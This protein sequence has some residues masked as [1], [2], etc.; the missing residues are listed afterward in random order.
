MARVAIVTGGA[1]E[2][3]AAAAFRLAEEGM[4]IALL[5]PDET[6]CADTVRRITGLGHRCVVLNTDVT[7][8]A[9][10]DAA[11]TEICAVLGDP[12]V[13]LNVTGDA[14]PGPLSGL[15]EHD[16]Y[17]ST[18]ARLRGVFLTSRAVVDP[19]IKNGWGRIL[20]LASPGHENATLR[21][22]LD[23]VLL[24]MVSC[25]TGTLLAL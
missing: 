25:A 17:A 1:G 18:G 10:V 16:W 7:D 6:A 5:D 8:A 9:S 20:T 12:A 14:T 4:D 23:S 24:E 19:M 2:T 11:L 3:G 22:G 13:L 15:S 21:A